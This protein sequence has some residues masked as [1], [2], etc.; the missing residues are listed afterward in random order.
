MQL[1]FNFFPTAV[2]YYWLC[3]I[4]ISGI[5]S[6]YRNYIPIQKICKKNK[7]TAKEKLLRIV[8]H[9]SKQNR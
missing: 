1:L 3:K 8:I 7:N 5:L 4:K 9:V 6:F 2:V